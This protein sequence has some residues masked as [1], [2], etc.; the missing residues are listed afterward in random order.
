[1]KK[2]LF[3]SN[4][5]KP[6]YEEQMSR[7]KIQLGNVSIPCIEAA[8]AMGYEIFMGINRRNAEDLECDYDVKFYNSSTYRSLF[9]IKSNYV[10]YKNLNILLKTEKID[11]IHCNTPIGGIVG[12]ICGKRAKIPKIIYTAHGFHFYKG[13]PL[14]NRTIFKWAEMWMARYTDA[15]ITMNEED[16]KAAKKFKLR[17]SGNVYYVPGVGI[18][19][20]AYQIDNIDRKGLRESFG[21]SE[22]DIILISMG[23]LVKRKNYAASIRAIAKLGNKRI[24][25]LICG[26]GPELE[27]LQ[28]LTKELGV[29]EQIHFLGFRKDVKELLNIADMFLL[30]SYQEGLPRS[31]MEAM[32]AGLP[33]IVSKIRGNI[34]LIQNNQGGYLVNPSSINEISDKIQTIILNKEIREKMKKSNLTTIERFDVQ[35][36]KKVVKQIYSKELQ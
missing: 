34:D 4:S 7:E 24:H 11:V 6:T 31:L 30:T 22:E 9:D 15:I 14:I 12:R 28:Q 18:D 2:Y 5:T 19:T 27:K 10:A 35:E 32:A 20:K 17:N 33:C 3:I 26:R 36:V 25:L 1:M 23:D 16:Y 29:E 13:A 8:Q 21:M